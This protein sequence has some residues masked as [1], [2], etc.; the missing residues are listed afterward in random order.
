MGRVA[1]APRNDSDATA[2]TTRKRYGRN[3]VMGGTPLR[4]LALLCRD[5]SRL[6]RLGGERHKA[7]DEN[8][9]DREPDPPHGHL[10]RMA[11]GSLAD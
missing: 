3:K 2:T 6:L 4:G 1:H 8:K 10:S 7:P 9:S 11:G 5:A